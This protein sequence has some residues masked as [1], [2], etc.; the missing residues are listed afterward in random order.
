[1]NS[2]Y[3]RM[4]TRAGGKSDS[5]TPRFYRDLH[6][7]ESLETFR[8]VVKETDLLIHAG[9]RLERAARE[10]VLEQRGYIE[11][12]ARAHPSFLTT[13]KPWNVNDPAPL[14][15][16]EMIDAGAHAGVGPMAAVAGAVAERVA[17]GL[18]EHSAAVI[19][20]NGGD[21]FMC[22]EAPATIAVYAGK[23]PLSLRI[24]I[25]IDGHNEPKA[26]CTSSGK[27]GHSLSLG[28][29]DAVCV[30]ASNGALA[31]AAATSVG[32]RVQSASDISDAIAFARTISGVQGLVVIDGDQCGIWGDIAVV[33][34]K[35]D[36]H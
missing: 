2:V 26:I 22:S 31:D 27:L 1:M 19:V 12:Y 29:A 10:L 20:E 17:R 11:A 32:N 33:P 23:S 30:V 24:G 9:R 14:I 21:V 13:L 35:L 5:Y 4:G 34:L 3:E 7:P 6:R 18:L 25:R 36:G 16:R 15:V 8:V 28:N